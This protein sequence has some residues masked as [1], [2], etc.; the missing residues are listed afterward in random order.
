MSLNLTGQELSIFPPFPQ[1][2]S[3][4]RHIPSSGLLYRKRMGTAHRN[5]EEDP[6]EY[7]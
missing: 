5:P 4:D 6:T 2:N 3:S 7:N 1:T